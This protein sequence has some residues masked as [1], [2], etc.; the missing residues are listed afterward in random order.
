[1]HLKQT[2]SVTTGWEAAQ[3]TNPEQEMYFHL[4]IYDRA[5][6]EN[7]W[8]CSRSCFALVSNGLIQIKPG[9]LFLVKAAAALSELGCF[10]Q[11]C[12][13]PPPTEWP[14]KT[15]AAW[16]ML[17]PLMRLSNPG[18][19]GSHLQRPGL[20]LVT[21]L[22]LGCGCIVGSPDLHPFSY[23]LLSRA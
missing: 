2:W 18:R 21:P 6:K 5:L 22:S 23:L 16:L 11:C 9:I 12:P 17:S 3:V 4:V 14:E 7:R 1:M 20:W 10:Y 13:L 15:K 19:M 8:R